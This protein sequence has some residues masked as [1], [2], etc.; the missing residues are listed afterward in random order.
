MGLG[1]CNIPTHT[2]NAQA[3]PR[4]TSFLQE[5][6][7]ENTG[8]T[9]VLPEDL[10]QKLED[11]KKVAQDACEEACD[12]TDIAGAVNW[13]DLS[14][15]DAEYYVASVG[16]STGYRVYIEE[17]SPSASELRDFIFEYLGD[18]GYKEVEV[19]LDW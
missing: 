7:M 13:G 2:T 8:N 11:L 12:H 5:T 16:L 14:C 10:L 6:T 17:A 3:R 1:A 15:R 4:P 9:L 18:R 19:I